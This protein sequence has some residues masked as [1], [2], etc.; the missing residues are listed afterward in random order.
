[1]GRN[2]ELALNTM[3]FVIGNLGSKVI[4][5]IMV[6]L[7]TIWLTPEEFGI[8]DLIYSYNNILVL[9][10]GLGIADALVV[11][12]IDKDKS[13]AT[14]QM[15]T[16]L[17]F[18]LIWCALFFFIFLLLDVLQ[19]PV[20]DSINPV[21]WYA[22]AFLM[23][24]TSSRLFQSFCRGIKKM[25]VFSFTGIISAVTTAG[26]SFLLIPKFGVVG[27]MYSLIIANI[28]TILF[29]ILYPR[30]Y[31]YI[32]LRSFSYHELKE[33]LLYSI[34]L[35]PNSIM[36]WLILGM[37]RPLLEQY[38]GLTAL[39]ILAVAN[40]IPMLMDMCYG[41]FHQSW[42]VTAVSE[43]DKPDFKQYYNKVFRSTVS[44]QSFICLLLLLS[45]K[46]LI[47]WFVDERYNDVWIYVPFMCLTV[48]I[49]N[50]A[51][52]T[53][54]IFSA[55]KQTKYLFYTVIIATVVSVILNFSLIPTFGLWGA[56]ISM[57]V[58]HLVTAIV[59]IVFGLRFVKIEKTPKILSDILL[60]S[61]GVYF[62]MMTNP[63]FRYGGLMLLVGAFIFLNRSDILYIYNLVRK[64]L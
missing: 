42:I 27:Y 8:V 55:S 11:F 22:F 53:S 38:A 39:G 14:M 25:K 16:A 33:M 5:F 44:F 21:I 46:F 10:V 50:M 48:V 56:L 52:F 43:Y 59:R 31:N 7:Y 12:P 19:L 1:M 64:K 20:L 29:V 24:T 60:C 23:T 18:H 57:F 61:I 62:A 15:T 41:F 26:L 45:Y 35:I 13:V 6:P 9:I 47:D 49:S 30:C 17:L 40:K 4:G 2:K 32:D 37:N 36:W 54:S 58:A 63:I 51:T 28:L 3:Y 34:P